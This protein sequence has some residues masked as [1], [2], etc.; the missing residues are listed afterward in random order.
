MVLAKMESR[1][2]IL[3]GVFLVL[4]VAW[5][6]PKVTL[7]VAVGGVLALCDFGLMRRFLAPAVRNGAGK[8]ALFVLQAIK[9]LVMGAVLGTLFWFKVINPIASVVG[10]S[11][12]FLIPLL[13]L[14]DLKRELEEVA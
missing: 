13:H 4:S 9:Y 5:L 8:G 14:F 12:M 6:D 1:G 11:I 2:W 10:L 7:G 3:L